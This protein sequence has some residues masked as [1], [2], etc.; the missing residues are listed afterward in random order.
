VVL[1]EGSGWLLDHP[2]PPRS[3][4]AST[5]TTPR[6]QLSR[7]DGAASR[8][9]RRHKACM[10]FPRPCSKRTDCPTSPSSR[11]RTGSSGRTTSRTDP[12]REVHPPRR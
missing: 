2:L 9:R 8:R 3:N 12:D 10:D 11:S 4:W 5:A 7:S 6:R 1:A